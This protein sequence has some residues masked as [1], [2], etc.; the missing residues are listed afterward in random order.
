MNTPS[1]YPP[2]STYH[3]VDCDAFTRGWYESKGLVQPAAQAVPLPADVLSRTGSLSAPRTATPGSADGRARVPNEAK[4]YM[5][6]RLGKF[7]RDPEARRKFQQHD[8]KVLRFDATWDDRANGGDLH[9]LVLQYYLADDNVEV[10]IVHGTNTGRDPVPS[11]LRK[12]Q[13]PKDWQ[14]AAYVRILLQSMHC[15]LLALRERW[16]VGSSPVARET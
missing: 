3:I 10:R 15:L 11:L 1:R 4:A 5:E 14:A 16:C 8:G 6:A 2:C 12:Q 13:L 9:H 7:V